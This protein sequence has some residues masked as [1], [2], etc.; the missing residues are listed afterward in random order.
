VTSRDGA[1]MSFVAIADRFKPVHTLD[2]RDLLDD[3]AAALAG[4]RCARH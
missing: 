3:L 4:C 1:V 2:V